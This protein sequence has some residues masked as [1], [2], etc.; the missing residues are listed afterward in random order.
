MEYSR[1]LDTHRLSRLG[2]SLHVTDWID[3]ILLEYKYQQHI[4]Y[5]L[6]NMKIEDKISI[7]KVRRHLLAN[8]LFSKIVSFSNDHDCHSFLDVFQGI[9]QS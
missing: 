2:K 9:H 3:V 4:K 6:N 5:K 1:G 8:H 7:R